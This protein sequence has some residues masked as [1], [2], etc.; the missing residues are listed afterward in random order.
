MKTEIQF[1]HAPIVVPPQNFP[2]TKSA[3]VW[4]FPASVRELENGQSHSRP[5]L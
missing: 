5:D 1:T 3:R 2:P 4:N